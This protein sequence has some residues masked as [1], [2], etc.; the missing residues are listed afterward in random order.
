MVAAVAGGLMSVIGGPLVSGL[1]GLL[2]GERANRASAKS[3]QRQM[4]FQERMS[5]TAH[6]REVAD[7]R[8]AGLNPILS[9]T[10]GAG[11]STPSGASSTFED[12]LG[13]ATNSA[14]QA[15]MLRGALMQQALDRDKT[16]AE[17]HA[18]EMQAE[19]AEV[20]A[21]VKQRFA[22]D[23]AHS[24]LKISEAQQKQVEADAKFW[25][26]DLG[27]MFKD[28]EVPNM[29]QILRILSQF[30]KPR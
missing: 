26:Q 8:A 24:A 16:R 25:T 5:S 11:S 27:E 14:L 23:A 20:E 9:G 7:L 15:R 12:V 1:A 6:Q 10:G 29:G 22:E 30:M 21:R 4:E 17:T 13:P 19:N 3:V 18:V 28:G 2:G